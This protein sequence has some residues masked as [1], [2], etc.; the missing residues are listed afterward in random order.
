MSGLTVAPGFIDAHSHNDWCALYDDPMPAFAPFLRQGIVVHVRL[1]VVQLQQQLAILDQLLVLITAVA[2]S[3][4]STRSYQA[5]L[6]R[7]SRTVI[8]G[9][10]FMMTSSG[11][12]L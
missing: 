7:T 4:P 1:I 6:A 2:L 9:W 10:I 3:R 5:A 8:I 12:A 11:Y